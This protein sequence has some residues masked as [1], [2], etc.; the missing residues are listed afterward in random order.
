MHRCLLV[1]CLLALAV[2]CSS[3]D[4]SPA[5]TSPAGRTSSPPPAS[6]SERL[7]LPLL[8]VQRAASGNAEAP[9]YIALGDSL[10][11]GIGASV[12]TEKGF[13]PLIHEALGPDFALL[14][15]GIAGDN[16]RDLLEHGPL[17]RALAEISRRKADDIKG[18]EVSLITLEIGGNDLLDIYF[19]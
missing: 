19:H 14:N 3:S 18:N 11:A 10:S 4:S 15:L 13:V 6:S 12:W 7:P 2:A 9:L 5:T 16:S 17:D 8:Q 1:I